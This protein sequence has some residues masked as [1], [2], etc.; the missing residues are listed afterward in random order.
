MKTSLGLSNDLLRGPAQHDAA[1]LAQGNS[2]ELQQGL[3]SDCDLGKLI[4]N[5]GS[6]S[7]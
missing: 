7:G 4:V 3:V 6:Q 2:G 5:N 1:G